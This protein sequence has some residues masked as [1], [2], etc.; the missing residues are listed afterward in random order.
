MVESAEDIMLRVAR[1]E[2]DNARDLESDILALASQEW[3]GDVTRF[4][5]IQIILDGLKQEA[6]KLSHRTATLV[7]GALSVQS[8]PTKASHIVLKTRD[9]TVR[10]YAKIIQGLNEL[11][12]AMG[13][14]LYAQGISNE[15]S[16]EYQS[17][18]P[19]RPNE[20]SSIRKRMEADIRVENTG[21]FNVVC[22]EEKDIT[23]H[24]MKK[25][26]DEHRNNIFDTLRDRAGLQKH[27]DQSPHPILDELDTLVDL[28][29]MVRKEAVMLSHA[30][31]QSKASS[32]GQA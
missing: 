29:E 2:H 11:S 22:N 25:W 31:T 32:R 27:L 24:P 6:K 21:D 10:R 12:L 8:S 3:L 1:L 13:A 20:A 28:V 30:I 14:R 19:V 23:P 5:E 7:K 16:D 17:E 26:F 18:I 4:P 15:N 9:H